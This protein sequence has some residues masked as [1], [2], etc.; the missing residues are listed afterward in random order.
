MMFGGLR[1]GGQIISF[2]I[3]EKNEY[4]FREIIKRS[5]TTKKC[6][7]FKLKNELTL[8]SESIHPSLQT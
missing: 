2:S 8:D 1:Q 7:F 5:K 6:T 3:N 4:A